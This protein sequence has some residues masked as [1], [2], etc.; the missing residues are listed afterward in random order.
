MRQENI[1]HE[2]ERGDK[3]YCECGARRLV[4][5]RLLQAPVV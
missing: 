5:M 2:L 3:I 1:K 4:W